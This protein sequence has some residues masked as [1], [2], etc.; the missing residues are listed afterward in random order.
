MTTSEKLN[1]I[2]ARCEELLRSCNAGVHA[3]AGWRSKI[4]AI[5]D[6]F[7][8]FESHSHMAGSFASIR[9]KPIIAAWEGL[10]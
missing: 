2:A 6:I 8:D 7:E 10:V 5:E 4:A 1:A 9:A 3:E